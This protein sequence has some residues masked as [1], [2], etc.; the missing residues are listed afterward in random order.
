MLKKIDNVL[1]Y[2]VIGLGIL[3]IALTPMYTREFRFPR[4]R[5]VYGSR[6]FPGL[7]GTA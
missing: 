7:L 2:L 1:C 4:R 5:R 6:A 3:F